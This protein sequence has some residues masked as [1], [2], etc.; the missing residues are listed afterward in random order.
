MDHIKHFQGIYQALDVEI[1]ILNLRY[2]GSNFCD[3]K[4]IIDYKGE[5]AR[6]KTNNFVVAQP[7]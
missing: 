1:R 6:T 5:N 7:N 2:I 4:L 3:V